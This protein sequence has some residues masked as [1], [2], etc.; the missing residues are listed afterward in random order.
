MTGRGKYVALIVLLAFIAQCSIGALPANA[1]L[2]NDTQNYSVMPE[3]SGSQKSGSETFIVNQK[4]AIIDLASGLVSTAVSLLSGAPPPHLKTV[5]YTPAPDS[6]VVAGSILVDLSANTVSL[7]KTDGTMYS[8]V[9]DAVNKKGTLKNLDT[10]YPSDLIMQ[11]S[12]KSITASAPYPDLILNSMQFKEGDIQRDYKFLDTGQLKYFTIQ[13]FNATQNEAVSINRLDN[14]RWEIAAQSYDFENSSMTTYSGFASTSELENFDQKDFLAQQNSAIQ[15]ASMKA[16]LEWKANIFAVLSYKEGGEFG[17]RIVARNTSSG[18]RIFLVVGKADYNSTETNDILV[19]NFLPSF[20]ALPGYSVNFS[21]L[22]DQG[23]TKGYG[24]LLT[25]STGEK[26]LVNFP[27]D[28]LLKAVVS[29]QSKVFQVYV[30]TAGIIQIKDITSAYNAMQAELADSLAKT[31]AEVT[32]L[33]NSLDALDS[34]LASLGT[35]PVADLSKE[36]NDLAAQILALDPSAGMITELN[37]LKTEALRSVATLD[38]IPASAQSLRIQLSDLK[39]ALANHLFLMKSQKSQIEASGNYGTNTSNFNSF[40]VNTDKVLLLSGDLQKQVSELSLGVAALQSKKTSATSEFTASKVKISDLLNQANQSIAAAKTQITNLFASITQNK[41]AWDASAANLDALL[42]GMN[43]AALSSQL[44]ALFTSANQIKISTDDRDVLDLVS[45]WTAQAITSASAVQAS[46]ID[47]IKTELSKLKTSSQSFYSFAE[48]QKISSQNSQSYQTLTQIVS[49]LQ[50]LLLN[51]DS[52]SVNSLFAQIQPLKTN[53]SLLQSKLQGAVNTLSDLQSEMT[54][55]FQGLTIL[56]K[57]LINTAGWE[58]SVYVTP[59]G[60]TMYF[61]YTPYNFYNFL[62][63]GGQG[64]I[65]NLGPA[66]DGHHSNTNPFEDSDLY[67]SYFVDGT[68]T[69][70]VNMGLN[71]NGSES[72][73]MISP[74]GNRIY[75]SKPI[76][77][78]SDQMDLYYSQKKSDG[79]WGSLQA[80]NIPKLTNEYAKSNPHISND[81]KTVYFTVTFKVNGVKSNDL[82]YSTLKSDG[83]WSAPV[84]MGVNINTMNEDEDQIWVSADQNTIYFNRGLGLFSSK[85]VSGVWQSATALDFGGIPILGGE[86]SLTA[87]G[88]QLFF[89]MVDPDIKDITVVTSFL[90]PDGH[91]SKPIS[92]DKLNQISTTDLLPGATFESTAYVDL[93]APA[94]NFNKM[95]LGSNTQWTDNGDEMMIPGTLN[96][97]PDMLAKARAMAP[98]VLRYPGGDL[99]D[100]YNWRNGIGTLSFRNSKAAENFRSQP[101]LFGTDEMLKLCAELNSQPIFT[102]NIMT[103]TP[104]DAADWVKY[105]NIQSAGKTYNGKPLPKVKY[106]EIGNEP[107]LNPNITPEQYAAKVDAFIKAMKAVD[108][109]IQF[110]VALRTSTMG[111]SDFNDRFLAAE[112]E[113]FDYV[114]VHNSYFPLSFYG[115]PSEAELYEAAMASSSVIKDDFV[116]FDNLLKK[117]RPGQSIPI[118]VTEF[119]AIF[120]VQN[121]TI[122]TSKTPTFASA[123]YVADLLMAFSETPNLMMANFWSLT[124]NG[125]FG[126]VSNTGETRPVYE[127]FTA[128]ADLMKGKVVSLDLDTPTFD[129]PV[130]GLLFE[131]K[132]AAA[133][134]SLATLDGNTLRVM[135][136]NKDIDNA[137]DFRLMLPAGKTI[138]SVRVKRISDDSLFDSTS[139]AGWADVTCSVNGDYLELNLDPHSISFL[140]I[141]IK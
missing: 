57:N 126:A 93:N 34:T 11:F 73:A 43:L 96:F 42:S 13:K 83:K 114:T 9:Y 47:A 35:S 75:L 17:E 98:T 106:W 31:A 36:I 23:Y 28:D 131:D 100:Y 85:K 118:A 76:T 128:Y 80:M 116:Y 2:P 6:T 50:N 82:Y 18:F 39:Q 41:S 20:T 33:T 103:M 74:D 37:N 88:K 72:C 99:S 3:S 111:A 64:A 123:M 113:K 124:G 69:T 136:L 70:P 120:S 30:D 107:Y 1:A 27:K 40:K 38:G 22:T 84:T 78:G 134:E 119:N 25:S 125:D 86:M 24:L 19:T 133:V 101:I 132:N 66:R 44:A 92:V 129:N 58:D 87:D 108:P 62:V 109:T 110:G 51:Y 60:K 112:K 49:A 137:S 94:T 97:D 140:E 4:N 71:T 95:I 65:P 59:D 56:E 15:L 46:A 121:T 29:G 12:V 8:G 117:A 26:I 127:V 135:A 79:T 7:T 32:R 48:S 90:Q 122:D 55:T 61:M 53:A 89:S 68:W 14:G 138:V 139:D 105:T 67:V 10:A 104:Q 45:A 91:W 52:A 63:S 21:E 77:M 81:G 54:K 141:Q 102:V 130:V 5:S 16:F 115:N